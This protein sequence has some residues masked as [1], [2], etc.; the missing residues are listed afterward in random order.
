MAIRSIPIPNA[1]P[2]YF[3][4]SILLDSG[5]LGSTLPQPNI[6]NQPVCLHALHPFPPHKEQETSTSAYGSV[7]GKNEGRN[8]YL[9]V[10][11]EKFFCRIF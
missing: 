8:L 7:K 1:K 10:L 3:T 6:S 5:T 2:V 9:C 4:E 11:T